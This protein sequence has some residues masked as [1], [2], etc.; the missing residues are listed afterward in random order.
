MAM[1]QLATALRQYIPQ[2]NRGICATTGE[3][4]PVRGPCNAS[5]PRGEI[6]LW[7]PRHVVNNILVASEGSAK[8]AR[9]R[10]PNPDPVAFDWSRKVEAVWRSCDSPTHLVI[11]A[12]AKALFKFRVLILSG[13]HEFL[14]AADLTLQA[15]RGQYEFP[16]HVEQPV[17]ELVPEA[18]ST[19]QI[20]SRPC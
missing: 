9:I 11:D 5:C 8:L 1:S 12:Q 17:A 13:R 3:S 14:C 2:P 4:R 19:P 7:Q 6:P 10:I 16:A 15:P 18:P 20:A